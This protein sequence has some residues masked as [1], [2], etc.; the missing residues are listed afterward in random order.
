MAFKSTWFGNI[1]DDRTLQ[2]RL[3]ELHFSPAGE[4]CGAQIQT[5]KHA[6]YGEVKVLNIISSVCF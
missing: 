3:I 2:G 6:F 5:C 1:Q 4:I